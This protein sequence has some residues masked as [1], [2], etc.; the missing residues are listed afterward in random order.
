LNEKGR[1]LLKTT[2]D[3]ATLSLRKPYPSKKKRTKVASWWR[4]ASK[5]EGKTYLIGSA[6]SDQGE[7]KKKKEKRKIL[8]WLDD[9]QGGE[10]GHSR[11]ALP[12]ART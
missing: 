2:V 11:C 12:C 5:K 3:G 1:D 7:K 6:R 9:I 8:R 4:K 10:R